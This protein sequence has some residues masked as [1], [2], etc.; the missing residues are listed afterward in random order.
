MSTRFNEYLSGILGV[1]DTIN[2]KT[3]YNRRVAVK[4]L[5]D[6]FQILILEVT[7]NLCGFDRNSLRNQHLKTRWDMAKHALSLAR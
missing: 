7:V 4:P 1:F 2:I 3:D 5:Y 6:Y